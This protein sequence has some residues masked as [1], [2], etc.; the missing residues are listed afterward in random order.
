MIGLSGWT[1]RRME[2]RFNRADYEGV[3]RLPTRAL[4]RGRHAREA[5]LY[6]TTAL[7]CLQHHK[8]ARLFLASLDGQQRPDPSTYHFLTALAAAG[9]DQSDEAQKHLTRCLRLEPKWISEASQ[10]PELASLDL[11]AAA[12][13]EVA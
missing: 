1:L 2:A 6:R 7:L 11:S 8:E 5:S 4:L 12:G 10:L 3:A 9:L 13:A